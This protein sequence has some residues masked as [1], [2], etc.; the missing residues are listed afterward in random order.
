MLNFSEKFGVT[1]AELGKTENCPLKHCM[2][3]LQL[4]RVPTSSAPS[5]LHSNFCT[6]HKTSE[7]ISPVLQELHWL[8]VRRRVD[9]KLATLMFKSLHSCMHASRRPRP[10][11]VSARLAASHASYRGPEL[12]WATGRLI[13]PDHGFGK[14]CL[15][16]CGHLTV[17]QFRRQLKTFFLSRT[18]LWHL[19]T[20]AFRR[21]I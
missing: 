6:D 18:R 3:M 19:V 10:V 5:C 13:S 1:P 7:H 4:I 12:V 2:H 8:P 15:L 17:C 9:F 14:S 11:A 16:H 20:F 21:W